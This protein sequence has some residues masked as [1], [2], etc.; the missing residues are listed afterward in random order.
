MVH[1]HIPNVHACRLKFRGASSSGRLPVPG[2][3]ASVYSIHSTREP[4][5]RKDNRAMRHIY[6]CP[7]NFRES[8]ATRIATFPEIVNGLLLQ[9]IVL[10]CV[11]NLKSVALPISEI[12]GG[13]QKNSAVLRYAHAPFS[14]KF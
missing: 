14:P 5:Y 8:L 13:T 1:F 2:I 11:Q 4:C 7:E 6:G 10:K 9:S 3:P 12:I